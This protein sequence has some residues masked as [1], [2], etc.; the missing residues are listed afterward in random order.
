MCFTV[1]AF[2]FA[3][4]NAISNVQEN[5]VGVKL[6]GTHQLLVCANDVNI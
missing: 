6:N 5:Q 2:N 4:E 1:I 3:I